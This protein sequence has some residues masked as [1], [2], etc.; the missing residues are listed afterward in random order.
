[1]VK[2]SVYQ[3]DTPNTPALEAQL[4]DL[5]LRKLWRFRSNAKQSSINFNSP[6]EEHPWSGSDTLNNSIIKMR[7]I[8]IFYGG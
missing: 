6:F 8:K 3:K 7:L 1:M 2:K 4:Q 5:K